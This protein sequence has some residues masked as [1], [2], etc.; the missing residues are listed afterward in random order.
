MLKINSNVITAPKGRGYMNYGTLNERNIDQQA[1]GITLSIRAERTRTTLWEGSKIEL[2]WPKKSQQPSLL[3]EA[4]VKHISVDHFWGILSKGLGPKFRAIQSQ[5]Q[6][7]HFLLL[8]YFELEER[9][10]RK[11]SKHNFRFDICLRVNTPLSPVL[12][13]I[14]YKWS[15]WV[16]TTC[17]HPCWGMKS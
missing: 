15:L 6:K 11:N 1:I 14:D 2:K 12:N 10:G 4:C 5:K 13:R 7:P 9:H 17:W 16:G 3:Q 8:W